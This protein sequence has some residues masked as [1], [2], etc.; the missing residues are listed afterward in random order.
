RTPRRRRPRTLMLTYALT[1]GTKAEARAAAER[2]ND[3]HARIKGV[4]PVTGRPYD[5]L[6]PTLLLYVH[7]C[8][9]DSALVYERLT[10]G[11]LDEAG[12]QPFHDEHKPA[13][14]L[15]LVPRESIPETVTDL[16]SYLR[17]VVEDGEL[18]VTDAAR[19]V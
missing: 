3:V 16:R 4:D 5:A 14:E 9:V 1:F 6:D 13:A 15:V 18:R 17:G 19:R 12:R 8:L 2:I 7:A 10:V 11:R